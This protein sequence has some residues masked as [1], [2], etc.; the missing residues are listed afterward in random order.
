MGPLYPHGPPALSS[1]NDGAP[2]LRGI[3]VSAQRG[4][5]GACCEQVFHE[6]IV[7]WLGGA[8]STRRDGADRGLT[9]DRLVTALQVIPPGSSGVLDTKLD[10]DRLRQRFAG[11]YVAWR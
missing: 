1:T 3:P 10:V 6:A 11:S 4:K 5:A 2:P 8:E 7:D 9:D